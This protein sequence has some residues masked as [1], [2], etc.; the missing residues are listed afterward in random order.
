MG[1]LIIE[2]VL[3]ADT[4][5]NQPDLSLVRKNEKFDDLP[6]LRLGLEGLLKLNVSI[7]ASHLINLSL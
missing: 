5:L 2:S 4:P 6:K 1:S 7:Q 3:T